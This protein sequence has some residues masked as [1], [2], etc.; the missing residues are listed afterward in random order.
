MSNALDSFIF[1]T[2]KISTQKEVVKDVNAESADEYAAA[3][4]P[5][6]NKSPTI[7]GISK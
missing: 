4:K 3:I 1:S 6:K 7:N 2:P 5:I